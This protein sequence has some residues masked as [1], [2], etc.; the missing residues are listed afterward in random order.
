MSG[1]PS[2]RAVC[3]R[4]AILRRFATGELDH[5]ADRLVQVYPLLAGRRLLDELADSADHVAG[6]IGVP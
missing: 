2:P 3:N 6:A 4:G 5:L 1:K